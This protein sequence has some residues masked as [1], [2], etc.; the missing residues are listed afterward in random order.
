[1]V[2][3]IVAAVGAAIVG[4][5]AIGFGAPAYVVLL[6]GALAFA[7]TVAVMLRTGSRSVRGYGPSSE[8][9]FPTPQS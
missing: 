4:L 7:A 3:V 9:R 1:M 6:A 5:A 8:V 2:S